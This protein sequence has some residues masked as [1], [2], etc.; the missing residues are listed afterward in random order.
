MLT[1]DNVFYFKSAAKAVLQSL[2][3]MRPKVQVWRHQDR[4]Y[5]WN[6][7]VFMWNLDA[8]TTL[9]TVCGF[10]VVQANYVPNNY[11]SWR[12]GV[13]FLQSVFEA[14]FP[15]LRAKLLLYAV[16]RYPTAEEMNVWRL[17]GFGEYVWSVADDAIVKQVSDM[18]ESAQDL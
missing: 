11:Y 13:L 16:K 5:W 9:L 8:L 10:E 17:H 4:Y 7:H 14:V 6:Q 2:G 3:I 12:R 18:Q 15:F 1:T